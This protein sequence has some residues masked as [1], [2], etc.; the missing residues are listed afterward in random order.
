V[1]RSRN[2]LYQQSQG[3]AL[4]LLRAS[5]R[6][7]K[8]TCSLTA[9]LSRLSTPSI[10]NGY[11]RFLA[12][13]KNHKATGSG[14]EAV[15]GEMKIHFRRHPDFMAEFEIFLRNLAATAAKKAA[16]EG[17]ARV[18]ADSVR[19]EDDKDKQENVKE[20]PD[21][22]EQPDDND[23]DDDDYNAGVIIRLMRVVMFMLC[24]DTL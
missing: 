7:I 16:S 6:P 19:D 9:L 24:P 11:T 13:L 20:A 5:H 4:I 22:G 18:Q 12:I 23:D 10:P 17:P 14:T 8:N 1:L 15:H 21:D 3:I 2:I